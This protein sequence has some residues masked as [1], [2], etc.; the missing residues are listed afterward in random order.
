[1]VLGVLLIMSCKTTAPATP[2]TACE[3][4]PKE[5]IFCEGAA[6]CSIPGDAHSYLTCV[7]KRWVRVTEQPLRPG[8]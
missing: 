7:Q 4:L 1:M 8:D 2:S 3:P 5:D 6:F